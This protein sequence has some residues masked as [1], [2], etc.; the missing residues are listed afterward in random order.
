MDNLT[1]EEEELQNK[2][3]EARA[4]DLRA[5][6]IKYEIGSQCRWWEKESWVCRTV[7]IYKEVKG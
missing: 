6:E 4:I 5:E 1:R 3:E 2:F 7:K